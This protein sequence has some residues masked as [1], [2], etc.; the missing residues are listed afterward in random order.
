[1]T[2][3]TGSIVSHVA[4]KSAV[5]LA[6]VESSDQVLLVRVLKGNHN[7][8]PS[9]AHYMEPDFSRIKEVAFEARYADLTRQKVRELT[10][11]FLPV[12]DDATK[13][14]DDVLQ[15]FLELAGELSPENLSCDGE[16]SRSRVKQKFTQLKREWARLEKQIGMSVKEDLVWDYLIAQSRS[17]VLNLPKVEE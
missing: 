4:R 15:Q 5:Y 14:S 11:P 16:L 6:I 13:L 12:C 10:S 9:G 7:I 2:I 8:V 1:M 3:R 17:S